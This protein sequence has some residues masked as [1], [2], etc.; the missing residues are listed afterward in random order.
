MFV[1]FQ[2]NIIFI[3]RQTYIDRNKCRDRPWKAR[4]N[5]WQLLYKPKYSNVC[6]ESSQEEQNL[7][8]KKKKG[9]NEG[10]GVRKKRRKK[11]R[12]KENEKEKWERIFFSLIDTD[13]G[14]AGWWSM[15]ACLPSQPCTFKAHPLE[16]SNKL[17]SLQLLGPLDCLVWMQQ[18][19]EFQRMV[20]R[21]L[22]PT[23]WARSQMPKGLALVCLGFI[24]LWFPHSRKNSVQ[25][26]QFFPSWKKLKQSQLLLQ[27]PR[28]LSV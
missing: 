3:A 19:P 23:A 18:I 25:V 27:E 9:R 8:K 16:W 4:W 7:K 20:G 24:C 14:R 13:L 22:L 6:L 2:R 12:K 11:G 17:K 1:K 5:P 26:D 10:K 21:V 15:V 28:T